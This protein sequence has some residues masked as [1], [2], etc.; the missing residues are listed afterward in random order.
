MR[1]GLAD[2]EEP[3]GNRAEQMEDKKDCLFEDNLICPVT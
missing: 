2:G 3:E 1:S